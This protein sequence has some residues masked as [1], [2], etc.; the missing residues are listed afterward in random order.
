MKKI[1]WEPLK[2][3]A[4]GT[5]KVIGIGVAAALYGAA[6]YQSIARQSYSA[7]GYS[8]AANAIMDSDMWSH[9][10]REALQLL[11]QDASESDYK[12]VIAVANSDMWSHDKVDAIRDLFED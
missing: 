12:A 7:D 3:F 11:P 1:N 6:N 9:C 2:N 4:K 5:C 10:K 8:E